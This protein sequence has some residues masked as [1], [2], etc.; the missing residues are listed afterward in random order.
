MDGTDKVQ[1]GQQVPAGFSLLTGGVG[2]RLH[3]GHVCPLPHSDAPAF[4]FY[5]S[6][7]IPGTRASLP[8]P[9]FCQPQNQVIWG[10][11]L[12][13]FMFSFRVLRCNL[14]YSQWS[15]RWR[16]ETSLR[17]KCLKI[18]LLPNVYSRTKGKFNISVSSGSWCEKEEIG[19]DD[20]WEHFLLWLSMTLL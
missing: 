1:T 15:A 20:L 16:N 12:F 11:V 17:H 19:L 6:L 4:L 2:R 13:Y 14:F 7:G 3:S 9:C 18:G 10:V 8:T 5:E